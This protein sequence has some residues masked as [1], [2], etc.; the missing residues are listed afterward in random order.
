[1]KELLFARGA[2]FK[3]ESMVCL[4]DSKV[5]QGLPVA[6]AKGIIQALSKRLTDGSAIHL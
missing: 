1:M 6:K 4:C 5:M 2:A 3:T